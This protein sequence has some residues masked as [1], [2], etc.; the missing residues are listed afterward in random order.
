MLAKCKKSGV[1]CAVKLINDCFSTCY[2]LRKIYREI[3]I[4]RKL[5][6]LPGNLFTTKLIEVFIPEDQGENF[7]AIFL[8]LEYVE[9]DFKAMMNRGVS[10]SEDNITAILYNMLCAIN[11]VH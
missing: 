2:Q 1:K 9:S 6:E 5:T 4:L 3:L 7:Q 8:V 10:L 11:Y